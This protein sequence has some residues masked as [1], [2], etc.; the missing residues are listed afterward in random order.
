ME[1]VIILDEKYS[2]YWIWAMLLGIALSLSLYLFSKNVDSIVLSNYLQLGAFVGFAITI[3]SVIKLW[4]G[5]K[6]IRVTFED[7]NLIVDIF[8][9]NDALQRDRYELH[10]VEDVYLAPSQISIP[11]LNIFMDRTDAVTFQLS[12]EEQEQ[13]IYLFQFS[14]RIISVSNDAAKR[15]SAFLKE[16]SI[17]VTTSKQ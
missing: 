15:L 3:F 16:E 1:E 9:K 14:G 13:P 5:K 11:F 4:E 10:K 2:R 12:L 6:S 8:K 7:E 17:N